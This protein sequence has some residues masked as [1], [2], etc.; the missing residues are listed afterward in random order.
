MGQY[1]FTESSLERLISDSNNYRQK[2]DLQYAQ[3]LSR[4][5]TG[6]QNG[7]DIALLKSRLNVHLQYCAKVMQTYFAEIRGFSWLFDEKILNFRCK[8]IFNEKSR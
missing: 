5:R 1:L 6:Q 4:V 2:G 7:G 8:R 3:L